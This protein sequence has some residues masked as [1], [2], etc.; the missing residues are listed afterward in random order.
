MG[1]FISIKFVNYLDVEKEKLLKISK[2]FVI[3]LLF[4]LI[5]LF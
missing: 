3:I 5:I 2:L 4:I 1:I